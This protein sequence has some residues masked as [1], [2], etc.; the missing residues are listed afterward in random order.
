MMLVRRV[1]VVAVM[2]LES[3]LALKV[4]LGGVFGTPRL[5]TELMHV[6][7]M[8]MIFQR[9][10]YAIIVLERATNQALILEG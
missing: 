3:L 8:I 1:M 2:I 4:V 6:A 10:V 9:T 7:M 5:L